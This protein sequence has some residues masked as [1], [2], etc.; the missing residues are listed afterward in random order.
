M[1]KLFAILFASLFTKNIVCYRYIGVNGGTL[2]SDTFRKSVYLGAFSTAGAILS[3][4][5]IFPNGIAY[6]SPPI[7]T[8]SD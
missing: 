5:W 7:T 4:V 3:I 6:F 2:S 1:T 8:M